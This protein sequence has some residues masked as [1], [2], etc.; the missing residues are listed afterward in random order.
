MP[1]LNE[2][3]FFAKRKVWSER[4]NSLYRPLSFCVK[5][6]TNQ[7]QMKD[8]YVRCRGLQFV[9]G[10]AALLAAIHGQALTTNSWSSSTSSL[11]SVATNWSAVQL[12]DTSFDYIL[13]TNFGSKTITMDAST[14]ALNRSVRNL[15]VTAPAG[16]TNTLLIADVAGPAFTT[17]RPLTIGS[18]G[19]LQVTNSSLSADDAFDVTAGAVILDSGLID[20]TPNFFDVRIGRASGGTGTMTVNGGV[21]QTYGL[22]VGVLGN[23]RG[24]FTLNGGTVLAA[25]VVSLGESLNSTG[26]VSIVSGQFIATNDI[27]KVGNVSG[28]LWTQTGGSAMLAFLSI[29]DNA[30]GTLNLSQGDL[31]VTPNS[32]TDIT[33]VGNFGEAKLNIGGG[34]VWLRGEFHVADNPG[35]Q[36]SVSI[37]G[38]Q[39]SSTNALVAIGRYGIGELTITNATAFF[40]NTSVGRH[41][42][43]I[44]TLTVKSGGSALL[45]DDLSIG[46]FANAIGH[47]IVSGGLLSLTNDRI[48]VG[49]EGVGDL[50]VNSGT[51][52]ARSLFVG[53]SPDGTNAPQGTVNLPGG[54][55]LISSNVV[56]GTALVSTGQVN[57]SGGTL[58]VTNAVAG[59][60]VT[61]D[62]GT[63]DLLQGMVI[64]DQL[65][66]TNSSGQFNFSGGVLELRNLTASNGAPFVM[67]DGV[68][69]ATLQLDGGTYVFSD[70]LVISSNATVTG[71]GT[72][73]GTISNNGTLNTN[74]GP[75]LPIIS[76]I[77]KSGNTATVFFPTV[78]GPTYSLEY[79][80]TLVDPTWTPILPGFPG[81]GAPAN[82]QDTNAIGSAR[83]YRLHVQ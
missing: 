40:T 48:W 73:I 43:A 19:V 70:G 50:T 5:M 49:R 2:N 60:S 22:K 1:K 67:G 20:T 52:R 12:P 83:F 33:R 77:T 25:S 23:S 30:P 42:G 26:T 24:Q 14:A 78:S 10:T 66:L 17:S 11:W 79:K 8:R 74:C 82:L 29:G 59:G 28:G 6:L 69:A 35:V 81:T 46:R 41:D 80:N 62:S 3:F 4:K 36:G 72:I 54:T 51:V 71:C 44:G 15:I 68:N 63:F 45:V 32:P 65:R 58:I 57:V 37:T 75:A 7:T 31:T 56:I 38:G 47:T 16:S 76:A 64:A 27:T 18:G 21:L 53:M 34:S 13:I 9:I 55:I 39:L 61:V